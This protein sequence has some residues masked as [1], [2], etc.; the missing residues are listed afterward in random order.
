MGRLNKFGDWYHKNI[1]R[2]LT[3]AT[4]HLTDSTNFCLSD[5]ALA[6][7]AH[8]Q[9]FV[10][11]VSAYI[12]YRFLY[13]PEDSSRTGLLYSVLVGI[14]IPVSAGLVSFGFNWFRTP[15]EKK[16]GLEL[17]GFDNDKEARYLVRRLND[18]VESPRLIF[19][20]AVERTD[21]AIDD[22]VLRTEG[23]QVKHSKK[24][25]KSLFSRRLSKRGSGEF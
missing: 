18:L 22:F 16:L 23:Y 8:I 12:G 24:A 15:L 9:E 13:P 10:I 1:Y 5:I 20:E 21:S 25:K 6:P 2:H 19:D 3:N 7:F 4:R 11:G 17:G 14:S